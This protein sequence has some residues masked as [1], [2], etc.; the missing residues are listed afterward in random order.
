MADPALNTNA[1]IPVDQTFRIR[2]EVQEANAVATSQA[3]ALY[4]SQNGGS[5]VA[6]TTSTDLRPALSSQFADGDATSDILPTGTGTFAAGVGEESDAVTPTVTFTA[7][8]HTE[9]EFA[10]KMVSTVANNTTFDLRLYRSNGTPLDTYAV[11]PRVTA[12]ASVVAAPMEIM[13]VV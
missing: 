1:S 2:F 13:A 8:G 7:S 3:F 4:V 11:T 5:Y 12:I 9:L 6:V 10:L